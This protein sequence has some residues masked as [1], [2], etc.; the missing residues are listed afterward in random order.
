MS[1]SSNSPRYFAAC[2]QGAQIERY[3]A[4]V[5][6]ALRHVP[7]DDPQGQT[8]GNRRFADPRFAN[9]HRVVL[10]ASQQDLDDAADFLVA[11]DHRIQLA[12][13]GPF[14]Q[15]DAVA[16][17]GLELLLRV[18]IGDAGGAAHGLQSLK[19]VGVGDRVEFEDVAGLGIDLRQGEQ[20]VFRRNEL[21]FHGGGQS[22][23]RFENI[24]QAF[25][26]LRGRPAGDPR[27]MAE[28]GLDDL[29]ELAAIDAD[30]IEQRP[31]NALS[32][33]QKGGQQVQGVDLRIAAIGSELLRPLDRLLS[34]DGEFV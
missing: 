7:L 25:T 9:Q 33:G 2:D 15:V 11:A 10:G 18:L 6:E 30:L 12:L 5:L 24:H 21:V 28:F 13:T 3:H 20:Q 32:L 22:L 31:G 8:F 17:E 19:H 1:R 23:G 14:D 16:L 26:R 29:I 27:Q 34:L 4:L